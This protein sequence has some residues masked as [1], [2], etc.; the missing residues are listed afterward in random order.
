MPS[1]SENFGHSLVEGLSA[2]KPT[3]TSLNVPWNDLEVNNSGFNINPDDIN[4]ITNAI[5]YYAKLNNSEFSK[6][7]LNASNYINSKININN[8]VNEYLTMYK[9]I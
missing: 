3:I 6:I 8:I 1:K 4:Q 5:E 2:G 7:Q 9:S